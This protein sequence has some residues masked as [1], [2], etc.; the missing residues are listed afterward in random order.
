MN[1][2]IRGMWKYFT[3]KKRPEV[4]TIWKMLRGKGKKGYK[5]SGNRNLPAG[6]F[7]STSKEMRIWD[8]APKGCGEATLQ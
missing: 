8:V 1:N 7:W 5:V 3:L 4:K 6:S 2:F